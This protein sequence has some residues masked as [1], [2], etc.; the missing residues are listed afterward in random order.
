MFDDEKSAFVYFED[1][2]GAFNAQ[3]SL[4][5]F[6]IPQFNVMLSIKWLPKQIEH[7]QMNEG[8]PT[9]DQ[10]NSRQMNVDYPSFQPT[11]PISGQQMSTQMN[12]AGFVPT[13]QL[14]TTFEMQD[15][16]QPMQNAN[17]FVPGPNASLS[18]TG[19]SA[20]FVP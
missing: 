6:Y 18:Q 19:N 4:Q 9:G 12:Q 17:S 7:E 10:K 5:G 20:G 8:E 3:S 14:G 2:F 11:L 16:Y 13:S 1:F 15:V